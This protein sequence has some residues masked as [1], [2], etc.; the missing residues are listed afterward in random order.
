MLSYFIQV[1]AEGKDGRIWRFDGR[2]AREVGRT[3][4]KV[5]DAEPNENM[6]D[7]MNRNLPI[8]FGSKGCKLYELRL[9]PGEYYPRIARPN[10][11]LRMKALVTT[12][13]D[14]IL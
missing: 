8:I 11:A 1:N 9:H 2:S 10:S 14:V 12:Q 3:D 7:L 5:Y 6:F 4:P 13:G